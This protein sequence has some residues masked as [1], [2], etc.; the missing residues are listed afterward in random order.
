MSR[1]A[2]YPVWGPGG[3]YIILFDETLPA[4]AMSLTLTSSLRKL[5]PSPQRRRLRRARIL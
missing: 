3:S 2:A 4:R 5:E 1:L